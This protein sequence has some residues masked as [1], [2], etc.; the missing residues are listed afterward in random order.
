M[1]AYAKWIAALLAFLSVWIA[2]IVAV[3][4]LHGRFAEIYS[5]HFSETPRERLF[6]ASVAFFITFAT[7]RFI[8]YSIHHGEGPFHDVVTS[9]GRHIHHLVW[10]ILLLLL[11]GYMWLAQI[12]IGMRGANLWG[13]RITSLLFGAG[14]ALTL[15]EFALWLDLADVYWTPQGRASVRACFFFGSLLTIGVIGGPFL[16][17]LTRHAIFE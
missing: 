5:L 13:G 15:D 6:L 16:H 1:H 9:G 8:T 10:G 7:V 3:A 11:V 17:A 12:G 4:L 14:A 2:W